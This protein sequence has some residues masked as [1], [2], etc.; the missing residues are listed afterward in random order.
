MRFR[1]LLVLGLMLALSACGAGGAATP[2]ATNAPAATTAPAATE[3]PAA[4]TASTAAASSDGPV[5]IGILGPFT[6]GAATVGQEQLNFAKLAVADF[7]KANGT[8]YELVEGDTELDPAKAV[9]VAQRLASDESIYALVGPAGSQE[10]T[11]VQPILGPVNLGFISPS[12]TR[13]DLTEQSFTNFFRVVPRDDVQ[14]ATNATFMVDV[15]KATKVWLIDD[16]SAYSTGL[17]DQV[18]LVL[19]EQGVTA[20]RESITQDDSDFSALVTRIKGDA[21]EVIFVSWQLAPQAVVFAKQLVEQGVTA[22]LFGA[23]GLFDATNFIE[24]AAGATDGAYVSF[25]AP[26]VSAVAEA[27]AVV[28]AYTAQ[29]GNAGPFGAPAYV[30][31]MVALE[32]IQR[33]EQ[34]G[35][36]SREAVLA[37]LPKTNMESS[38][39]GIPITFDAKGDLKDAAFFLFQ[40]KDGKFNLVK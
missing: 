31:T 25:F 23:D 8:S 33:A 37:E 24:G 26:D 6:G 27:K 30:A 11:A 39:L 16:Q 19:K 14:G 35:P 9:I 2:S 10:V 34:A 12:A 32:A 7:N 21:P 29:Y 17:N 13:V 1:F 28:E 22:T 15:L 18:E 36:L 38:I 20:T 3:A 4:T 40:V 5:R